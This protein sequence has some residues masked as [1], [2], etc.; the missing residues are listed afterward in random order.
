MFVWLIANYSS[1]CIHL[2][3]KYVWYHVYLNEGIKCTVYKNIKAT[4]N[5]MRPFQ[6]TFWKNKIYNTHIWYTHSPLTPSL[7][8]TEEHRVLHTSVHHLT[9][10]C[11]VRILTWVGAKR[12]ATVI[13]KRRHAMF[14]FFPYLCS[15]FDGFQTRNGTNRTKHGKQKPRRRLGK[16]AYGQSRVQSR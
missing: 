1:I 9:K 14:L 5:N 7:C 11:E 2:Y 10:D 8:H 4:R 15:V 13:Y 16:R 6:S 3:C 12:V